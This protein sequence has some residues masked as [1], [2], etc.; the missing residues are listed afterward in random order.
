MEAQPPPGVVIA[1][2]GIGQVL[3][4]GFTL[5]RRNFRLLATIAAWGLIPG[6]SLQ[7]LLNLG[8]YSGGPSGLG[9]LGGFGAGLISWIASMLA[10]IAVIT[11]C[12][13][14][15]VPSGLGRPTT[16]RSYRE[17]V[18]RI[19]SYLLLGIVAALAMIPLVLLIVTIP[20]AIYIG[21][22]WAP[23]WIAVVAERTGPIAALSRGWNLT[24]HSWWH[25]AMVLLLAGIALWIIEAVILGV[26]V[27]GTV[28]A[29]GLAIGSERGLPLFAVLVTIGS[30]LVRVVVE[31]FGA[32]IGVVLYYELRARAEGFDLEQRMQQLVLAE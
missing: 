5:A 13:E 9:M 23:A 20:L 6:Y 22:R 7:V 8:T 18:S 16:G 32:A 31:P 29:L 27:G 17:A 2:M 10:G 15:V 19:P 12:S 14:L 11:A 1:P 4:G 28:A 24:H 25:T 21:I 26:V 3:D 30:S